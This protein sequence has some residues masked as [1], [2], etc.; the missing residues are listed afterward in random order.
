[1]NGEVNFYVSII[2]NSRPICVIIMDV[3]VKSTKPELSN[4]KWQL[5]GWVFR[6]QGQKRPNLSQQE[7]NPRRR[8]LKKRW[9]CCRNPLNRRWFCLVVTNCVMSQSCY[10]LLLTKKLPYLLSCDGTISFL[11]RMFIFIISNVWECCEYYSYC[12]AR[13]TLF[14]VKDCCG[15]LTFALFH[16]VFLLQSIIHYGFGC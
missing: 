1:M 2:H 13:L 8:L 7:T 15:R 16:C 6:S 5:Y 9:K 4:L 12:D 10:W 3:V 14:S 11:I